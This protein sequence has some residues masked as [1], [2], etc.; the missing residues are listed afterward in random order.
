MN[1]DKRLVLS[2]EEYAP[3]E[4]L[5]NEWGYLMWD[6][7]EYRNGDYWPANTPSPRN[8][9]RRYYRL[10]NKIT[11]ETG[12]YGH[13]YVTAGPPVGEGVREVYFEHRR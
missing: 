9:R 11:G 3:L 4:N 1:I 8:I 12:M 5:V 7:A 2:T 10:L 13:H 6:D